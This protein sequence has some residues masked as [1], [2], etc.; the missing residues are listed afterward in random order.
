MWEGSL[1]HGLPAINLRH[2]LRFIY[3][4][5]RG[6]IPARHT[7]SR[8]DH[9][10]SCRDVSYKCRHRLCVNP[11]HVVPVAKASGLYPREREW[12][13]T[14]TEHTLH[15]LRKQRARRGPS[16][17]G[18]NVGNDRDSQGGDAPHDDR[19]GE[20]LRMGEADLG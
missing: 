12:D 11:F 14:T 17:K 5:E 1:M 4:W 15:Y 2:V 18:Q 13:G 6:P 8:R 19:P 16:K 20:G 3:Q 7:L 9:S 10:D